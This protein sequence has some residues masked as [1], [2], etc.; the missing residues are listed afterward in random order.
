MPRIDAHQHFW[1]YRPRDFPWINSQMVVLQRDFGPHQLQPLLEQHGCDGAITVQARH[2]EQENAWLVEQVRT[3]P[4]LRGVVGWLDVRATSL[5]D[6]LAQ[7]SDEPLLCG[8][9]HQVQDEPDPA[10]WLDDSAVN[11][12]VEQVQRA[13]YVWELLVTW[14]H[15]E[16]ATRFVRRHDRHWLVLDHCGKP[17]IAAGARRWAQQIAPLAAQPHV[18]C[19]LS[20]LV[21]E[22]PGWRWKAE[23]L[24]PFFDAALDAFGPQRLLFGSDWPVCLL[25]AEYGQVVALSD[26]A[27]S[28]LSAAERADIAGN[29]AVRVYR[30]MEV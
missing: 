16:D 19:K 2:S 11:T 6:K 23:E 20:G 4:G 27:L 17:D 7:W 29:N 1:R 5:S 25:A 26:R 30:L 18:M 15:L 24:R 28:K 8:V 9:R 21:T 3:L 10:A 14:R 13:G 22:T 12:G